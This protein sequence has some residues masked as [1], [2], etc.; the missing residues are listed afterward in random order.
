MLSI[1]PGSVKVTKIN[2]TWLLL[3]KS[4][5]NNEEKN[6]PVKIVIQAYWHATSIVNYHLERIHGSNEGREINSSFAKV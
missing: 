3:S 2:R 4:L 6:P 5:K 1:V